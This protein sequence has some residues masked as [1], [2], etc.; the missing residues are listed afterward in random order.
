MIIIKSDGSD[1]SDGLNS[2]EILRIMK[3]IESDSKFNTYKFKG[4]EM[5]V[6]PTHGNIIIYTD[7]TANQIFD[8]YNIFLNYMSL[9]LNVKPNTARYTN[10]EGIPFIYSYEKNIQYRK[11]RFITSTPA[12]NDIIQT[13][14]ETKNKLFFDWYVSIT[15]GKDGNGIYIDNKFCKP[16]YL[17]HSPSTIIYDMMDLFTRPIKQINFPSIKQYKYYE[18]GNIIKEKVFIG[19]NATYDVSY[20]IILH[21][22]RKQHNVFVDKYDRVSIMVCG[23]EIML[24]DSSYY[25]PYYPVH[26]TR[27]YE[28][29]KKIKAS[30][31]T[32]TECFIT[33]APLVGYCSRYEVSYEEEKQVKTDTVTINACLFMYA[34]TNHKGVPLPLDAMIASIYKAKHGIKKTVQTG[35]PQSVDYTN[36]ILPTIDKLDISQNLKNLY[37]GYLSHGCHIPKPAIF[38]VRVFAVKEVYIV[39]L[40]TNQIFVGYDQMVDKH[41]IQYK[42]SSTVLFS[43]SKL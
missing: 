25:S 13:V 18:T 9:D 37:R 2:S 26:H 39:N 6:V 8:M 1:G 4:I 38:A 30:S 36:A 27:Q 41:L 16:S 19:G 3:K 42:D 11:R 7:K 29:R 23:H 33:G 21:H 35:L 20:N 43:C 34:R 28:S 17:A 31:V 15:N 22:V 24:F 32:E 14:R 5:E 40:D 12:C 10:Q